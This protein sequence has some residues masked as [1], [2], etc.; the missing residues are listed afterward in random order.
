[1]LVLLIFCIFSALF[2]NVIDT[3][4]ILAVFPVPS[5]SHQIVFRPI[6]QELARRG[7]EV[8]VIT[9]D[10]AFPKGAT[11]PNLKEI[12][13]HDV[14]YKIWTE[15]FMSI[16]IDSKG[17]LTDQVKLFL[18][19]GLAGIDAQLSHK[20]VKNLINDKSIKF[21]LVIVE[22]CVRSAIAFSYIYKAP[23]ITISSFGA[24]YG[25]FEA[26]GAPIHPFL[27]PSINRKKNLNLTMWEKVQVLYDEYQITRIN[28]EFEKLETVVLRKHLGPEMPSISELSNNVDMLFL[29]VHPIFES[30]RPVPPS[31]VYIGGIHQ[32]PEN[33]LP[34]DIKSLLDSF[35]EGVIYISFGTNV[36]TSHFTAEQVRML[37]KVLS[38]LPYNVLMKW[39]SKEIPG[40]TN[41]IRISEW[42]PQSDLLKHPNVKLFITQGGLQSTDEA[43][44]AGVPLIGIPMFGDQ[45]LN[46]ERYVH[47]KIGIKLEME[48][49]NEED[50]RNAITTVIGD[51]SYRRNI[52]NLRK[53]IHDQPQSTLERAVWWTEH[54]L[55]HGGARHLRAPAANM[56]WAEYLE[57]ELVLTVHQ[58][59]FRP[60]TQE[61]AKRGHEVTVITPDP[62]FKNGGAPPN[63]TEVDVHDISYNMWQESFIKGPSKG[64][65]NDL[66]LQMEVIFS[67]FVAV[68]DAQIQSEQVQTIINDKSKKFDL[69][70]LEACV[71]PA[72]AFSYVFKNVPVILISSL[73]ALPGNYDLLGAADHPILYPSI[74]RQR[75]YN[76]SIWDKISELY[77]RYKMMKVYDNNEMLENKVL[78]KN[79]GPNIPPV[80]E[81]ENNVDMLFLNIQPIFEGIRPIPPSVIYMGGLHQKP[82]KELPTEN[83]IKAASKGK[84]DD[85]LAQMAVVLS[86]FVTVIDAQIQ[87]EQVQKIINDR[88]KQFDLLFI[89]AC[90]R[91]ALAFSYVFKNVPVILVS[92]VGALPGN[93]ALFGAAD[94]PTL[95]PSLFRQRL[96]NLSLWDKISELY[97]GYKMMK[98]YENNEI[99]EN[100]VLRKM[101]GA[102]IPHVKELENNVD[103]LFLNIHPIFEG[104]RPVPPSVVY[105][106][107]L[108]QKPPKELPTNSDSDIVK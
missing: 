50:F 43:I 95:Y 7:H 26:V 100:E 40:R 53:L 63:L 93:Y 77:N 29:N 38:Q 5:I 46:V 27:Y 73:G 86:T 36:D 14:S 41:N 59:V 82:P 48:T 81:L 65:E 90:V 75:L 67:T 24:S 21:D 33:K 55:R 97:N 102:D 25:N 54:V 15:K 61:L 76:L 80:K 6:T 4:R 13:V 19:I 84:K 11:P 12:D 103:M 66:L 88:T 89:E 74:F 47:H 101:F 70:F 69:L 31:V 99:L 42:W 17:R 98:L 91:P 107:G 35:K 78:K 105:M 94:H 79:F 30:I 58:V 104:I 68:L 2:V 56:S 34:V 28:S 16:P 83:F 18:E 8:T 87:T 72:L 51:D 10:P 39:N 45:W 44:T 71:R 96:H 108:H 23:L 92:S 3:A 37:V 1:M 20:D 57:I 9:P 60:L 32:K 22:A 62:V 64:N 85:L 49:L 52:V 106:G